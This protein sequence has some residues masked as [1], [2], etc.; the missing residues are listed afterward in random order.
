MEATKIS[1]RGN[2]TLL[3]RETLKREWLK[4][5]ALGHDRV[6]AILPLFTTSSFFFFI[7]FH[8]PRIID[9]R[10]II[11]TMNLLS[12]AIITSTTV[13]RFTRRTVCGF[14]NRKR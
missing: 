9:V 1:P 10:P 3:E 7:F 6:S 11:D 8:F 2:A 12:P 14:I 13:K 5:E 4:I